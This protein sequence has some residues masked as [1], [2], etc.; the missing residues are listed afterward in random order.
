LISVTNGNPFGDWP[1]GTGIIGLSIEMSNNLGLLFISVSEGRAQG[2]PF[3][4][5]PDRA[6]IIGLSVEIPA[7]MMC[8]HCVLQWKYVTGE[9]ILG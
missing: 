9:F 8:D 3:G 7:N 4:Y 1:D 2:D 5:W 6:G